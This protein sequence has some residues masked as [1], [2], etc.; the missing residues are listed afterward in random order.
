LKESEKGLAEAQKMAHIGNW[1]WDIATDKAFWSEEMF[2]IFGRNRQELPPPYNE[3]LNYI[4]PDDRDYFDNAVK[5]AMDG[6]PY[7]I[8]HRLVLSSGKVR[9]VHIKSEVIFN[10]EKIPIRIKGIVQD[11][12]ERKR[13]EQALRDSEARL[14]Q[15]YES[16]MFGILFYNLNGSITDSNDKFL[17][18]VGYTREDMQAGK[19]NWIKMTPPEYRLLDEHAVAELKATGAFKEPQ[20]KEYFRKDGSRVPI[21]LG[22]ATYDK[23]HQEGIAF[24]LDITERKKTE[25]ALAEIDRIRI[26]EIH[27]RIKNNLQVISSLLDL[28]AEKFLNKDVIK[29]F[30]E[31]QNRVLSMSLIHEELYK[32]EGT[33]TLDFSMYLRKLSENLFL[34]YSLNSKNIRLCMNL[35]EKAFFDMDTAVPLGIIVNELVSNSLKHA[36]TENQEGE[37]QIMLCR[38]EENCEKHE[39]VFNLAISDNGKGIPENMELK[40]LESLGLQLVSALVDQ[41]DGEIE[42]KREKGTEFKITFKVAE[43]GLSFKIQ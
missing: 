27:H 25:K 18:L 28:Q 3:Y 11:I 17:K 42:I 13:A 26:K 33:E 24:V 43:K 19:I 41:L 30:K 32:G 35:E 9:T 5:K 7:S 29:A 10:E 40:S 4:H 6:E 38:E 31:S 34:T 15:I 23:E 36:F 2:H 39:S 37:I 14:R 20:E 8:D 16:D 12:T 22:I 1:E 21:I